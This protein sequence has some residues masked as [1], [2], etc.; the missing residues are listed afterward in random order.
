MRGLQGLSSHYPR[1]AILAGA[2]WPNPYDF[3]LFKLAQ[4]DGNIGSAVRTLH[5]VGERDEINPPQMAIRLQ[6]LFKGKLMTHPGGHS[7]PMDL[8]QIIKY[9]DIIGSPRAFIRGG[10]AVKNS[11]GSFSSIG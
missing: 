7:V 11:L 6:K 1:R 3:D 4:C 2:A 8:D 9:K 5:V 10:D